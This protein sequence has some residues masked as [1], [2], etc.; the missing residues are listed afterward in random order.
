V[1]T[2]IVDDQA[3]LAATLLAPELPCPPGLRAWNGSDPARRLAV[4]RN[5]VVSS[6]IDALADA[7]PV[8]QAMVGSEFFRAMA[9]VFVRRHPPRSR[10]LAH[11][12]SDLPA[13]IERFEPARPLPYLPDLARLEHA[14]LRACHAADV[15]AVGAD[16]IR[17]ALSCGDGLH[18]LRLR[19]HPS[20]SVQVS[21]FAV[22]SLWAAHQTDDDREIS[23]VDP[24][25][26]ESA[27]IVRDGLEVVVLLLAPGF[28]TFIF[29][30]GDGEGLAEA[31]ALASTEAVDFDLGV[32]LSLLMRH[33]AITSLHI[34]E[35]GNP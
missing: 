31:A 8:T 3:A 10:V 34:P 21:A 20:T 4:H 11:Y 35:R 14:R 30:L 5:N 6:L 18:E 33:G 7:F 24:G 26:A 27:L 17:A 32:A 1:N 25:K 13:F 15:E 29:A 2:A 23:A 22:V 16:A 19:L 9:A 28:A 12:G